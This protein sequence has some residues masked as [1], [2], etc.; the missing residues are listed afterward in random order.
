MRGARPREGWSPSD[1]AVGLGGGPELVDLATLGRRL[2]LEG[3]L[4]LR[5]TRV[6]RARGAELGPLNL[7]AGPLSS[8]DEAWRGSGPARAGRIG[9]REGGEGRG[10]RTPMS[11]QGATRTTS[12]M[13][14]R[15]LVSAL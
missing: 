6:R 9:L 11:D 15:T 4:H 7:G 2:D 10:D 1:L 5:S 13:A 8:A 12:L 14:R 3:V